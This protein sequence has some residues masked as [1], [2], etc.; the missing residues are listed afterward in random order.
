MNRFLGAFA[1]VAIALLACNPAHAA[2][3]VAD[4]GFHL[5]GYLSVNFHKQP[6]GSSGVLLDELS[7]F[8]SWDGSERWRFF[9]EL[10]IEEPLHWR[11]GESISDDDFYF[12]IE[13]IYADY[14]YSESATLRMGRFLTPIGRWNLIHAAP[15]VWTTQRPLAT[16]NLFPLNI[17]GIMLQGAR[18]MGNNV[19]EY[20]VYGELVHDMY[21]D[22][23]EI[24]YENP[25]GAR[26]ALSGKVE[27]GL[28]LLDFHEEVPGNPHYRMLG[29]DFS[30]ARNGWELMAE[31]FQRDRSGGGRAGSGGYVQGIAPLGAGWFAVGRLERVHRPEDDTI[32]R[33]LL[34]ATWRVNEN[35]LVK[36]DYTGG[37]DERPDAPKGMFASFAVMF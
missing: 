30:A 3:D 22:D 2:E 10:E 29:L 20:A 4:D 12:D 37:S 6:G 27:V 25:F 31:V 17:N 35:T 19:L 33:W 15:L 13:R 14:V 11:E 5:G 8:V 9:S 23:H 7:L 26:L 28:S 16:E 1:S 24:P 18:P 36:V 32:E 21:E 34:G